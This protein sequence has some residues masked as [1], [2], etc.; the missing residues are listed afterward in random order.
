[1]TTIQQQ[2]KRT[3]WGF[4]L[5]ELIIVM[6]ILSVIAGMAIPKINMSSYRADAAAQQV[7][8]VFQTA[9]RT[10]LT[11]QYDVIV[12]VD[13]NTFGLRIA[14]DVNNDGAIQISEW[15]FWRP[16]GE[17]NRFAVPPKGINTATVT[18]SVIGAS[19]KTVDALPSII[20]HRDGSTSSDGEIY[21]A[22]TYKNRTDY[23]AVTLTRATGRTELYRL[24]G[25]GSAAVWQVAQ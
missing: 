21:I 13:T 11:R 17:G 15:K 8:S 9:Q 6:I 23:R 24:A 22:A 4:S 14:E 2:F 12:S 1:M 20:F 19:L 5:I 3:R 18:K 16:A 25:T 10:S 7:R